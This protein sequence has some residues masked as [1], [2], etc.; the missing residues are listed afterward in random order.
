MNCFLFFWV[1][2]ALL[3]PDPDCESGPGYGARDLWKKT[4]KIQSFLRLPS[5][6]DTGTSKLQS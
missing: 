4:N 1:I 6:L 3:D 2:L 5:C